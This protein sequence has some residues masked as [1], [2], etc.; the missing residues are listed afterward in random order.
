MPGQALPSR[1]LDFSW[2][3]Q[4]GFNW[5]PREQREALR[6]M[7]APVSLAGVQPLNQGTATG[8]YLID[9]DHYVAL[10]SD[11]YRVERL[12]EVYGWSMVAEPRGPGCVSSTARGVWTRRL[13]CGVAWG[14]NLLKRG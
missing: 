7:R 13:V 10:A 8:L 1:W 4:S 2:R 14:Q 11:T 6:A 12:P 5:L 3:G 9:G